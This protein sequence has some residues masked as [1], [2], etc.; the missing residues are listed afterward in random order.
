MDVRFSRYASS[1]KTDI[2]TDTLNTLLISP[3]TGGGIIRSVKTKFVTW[4]AW[5]QPVPD[6][7]E[8]SEATPWTSRLRGLL[9]SA[10]IVLNP[11]VDKIFMR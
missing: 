5:K 4:Q 8:A 11:N 10:C 3:H 7:G 2:V 9:F 1:H 6:F